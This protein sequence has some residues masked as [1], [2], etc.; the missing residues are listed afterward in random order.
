M[1]NYAALAHFG[2]YEP[3]TFGWPDPDTGAFDPVRDLVPFTHSGVPFGSM[4]RDVVPFFTAVLDR[5]VP[6]IPGGLVAGQ[7]G[8]YNPASR[9]VGGSPSFHTIGCAIDVN[10]GSNPMYAKDRPSGDF[11]LPPETSQIA[12]ELGGEWG[13]D[14]SYPQDWMHIE[15]H[16]TPDIARTVTSQLAPAG[17]TS[18]PLIEED[19]MLIV[20]PG[21]QPVPLLIGAGSKPSR[22]QDGAT[23]SAY[24]KA[25]VKTV[26]I[27]QRDYDTLLKSA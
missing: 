5:L 10:W 20:T 2:N 12:H 22:I 16:L 11:A 23:W 1:T 18:Q 7:C 9:T 24:T 8:C 15:C 4:H 19:T 21:K 3:W 17:G 25:G 27:S 6:L 14:W 26:Q 13:G